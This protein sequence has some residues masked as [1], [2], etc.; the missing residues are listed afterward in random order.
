MLVFF[1]FAHVFVV[2][3]ES[4]NVLRVDLQ[5]C[6]RLRPFRNVSSYGV[7]RYSAR[8]LRERRRGRGR[9]TKSGRR[10]GVQVAGIQI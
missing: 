7:C 2:T 6:K 1:E 4:L 5:R 8:K 10:G 9:R 3:Y